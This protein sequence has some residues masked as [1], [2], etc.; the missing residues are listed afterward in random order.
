MD[1]MRTGRRR[2]LLLENV[3]NALE[4]EGQRQEAKE[5]GQLEKMWAILGGGII[6]G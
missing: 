4:D 1:A 6:Q 3:G 5:E 2:G